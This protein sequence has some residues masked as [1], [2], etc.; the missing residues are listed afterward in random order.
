MHATRFVCVCAFA[1][2]C[3]CAHLRV[4]VCCVCVCV[5]CV[6]SSVALFPADTDR[7]T[8]RRDTEHSKFRAHRPCTLSAVHRFYSGLQNTGLKPVLVLDSACPPGH[9]G[10]HVERRVERH[11]AGEVMMPPVTGV[12]VCVCERVYVCVSVNTR[13]Q[14]KVN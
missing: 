8:I 5:L 14:T 9:E 12:C 3:V 10:T 11:A 6:F 7:N 2:V 4:C 13:L 1:C